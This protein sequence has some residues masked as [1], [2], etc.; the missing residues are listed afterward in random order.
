[1]DSDN[2]QG[3]TTLQSVVNASRGRYQK[4]KLLLTLIFHHDTARI[5]E[6]AELVPLEHTRSAIIGRSQP[7]FCGAADGHRSLADPFVSRAALEVLWRGS[8][9]V[10]RRSPEACRVHVNGKPLHDELVVDDSALR[11]GVALLLAHSVVLLLRYAVQPDHSE[12]PAPAAGELIGSSAYHQRVRQDIAR[13]ASSEYDVLITGETGTGKEV[14]AT[15]LHRLS[16]RNSQP[17]LSVNMAAISRELAAAA[18]FGNTRGAFTGADRA[19]QGFFRQ[20]DGGILFLDEVG[21]TPLEVQPL[22]LRAL[23]EREVQVVGGSVQPVDIR[24]F[25]ATDANLH[26]EEGVFRD[27]L[28][29][30]LGAAEISLLPLR[31]HP[32]DIG[33]LLL[34]Y[35]TLELHSASK[36]QLLLQAGS[37]QLEVAAWAEFFH[38][39]LCYRWPGNVRELINRVR[40][41]VLASDE[42]LWVPQELFESPASSAPQNQA[43]VAA[44]SEALVSMDVIDETAFTVAWREAEYEVAAIARCLNVSRQAVYRRIE[45]SDQIRTVQQL[46]PGE[47]TAAL[48][49]VNDDIRAAALQLRVSM[50]GLKSRV[51]Q[52]GLLSGG[53]ASG[54]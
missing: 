53:T 43:P 35:L 15:A 18:L 8:T 24:V 33:A 16:D 4:Q 13:L 10:L 2:P 38:R 21:D 26:C 37:P 52:M 14:V 31:Q 39:S 17:M 28:R 32:E 20:A 40:Q 42:W 34:H 11:T 30:R 49:E 29:H 3:N 48:E 46:S 7:Q 5:G 6:T 23:Q 19:Q 25:S 27:A 44:E 1:M 47:I 54:E 36:Q 51:R 22:L 45:S 41:A 12:E 50:S 9:L